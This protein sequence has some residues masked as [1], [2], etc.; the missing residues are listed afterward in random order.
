MF[1]GPPSLSIAPGGNASHPQQA[2]SSKPVTPVSQ[3]RA[4]PGENENT[5]IP[6]PFCRSFSLRMRTSRS[7]HD[8]QHYRS[9]CCDCDCGASQQQQLGSHPSNLV[10]QGSG[11]KTKNTSTTVLHGGSKSI[12]HGLHQQQQQ[13]QRSPTMAT[14]NP[15]T[16]VADEVDSF[17]VSSSTGK[18]GPVPNGVIPHGGH[19]DGGH[20]Q[21]TNCITS[22]GLCKSKG[23]CQ[24]LKQQ[25]PSISC[26]QKQHERGMVSFPGA[27]RL[28]SAVSWCVG[29][30]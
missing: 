21:H 29:I 16:D 7:F 30:T 9:E 18:D 14:S 4:Y 5:R 1:T 24:Q 15:A 17:A 6:Q 19:S 3:R 22:S 8:Y 11:V 25:Q 10:M 23:T 2:M 27:Y 20:T 12:S 26:Q 13:Q 28:A